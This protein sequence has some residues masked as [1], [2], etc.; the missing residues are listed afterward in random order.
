ML[1]ITFLFHGF[2]AGSIPKIVWTESVIHASLLLPKKKSAIICVAKWGWKHFFLSLL[3]STLNEKANTTT[4][5]SVEPKKRRKLN[6][7]FHLG[8]VIVTIS[9]VVSYFFCLFRQHFSTNCVHNKSIFCCF[10]LLFPVSKLTFSV[11]I[12]WSDTW[13]NHS[14]ELICGGPVLG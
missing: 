13:F 11:F 12:T 3:K 9:G 7:S 1:W 8:H 6:Y 10:I 5:T 14:I 4:K 2:C